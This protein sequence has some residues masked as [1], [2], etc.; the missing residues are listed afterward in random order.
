MSDFILTPPIKTM[1]DAFSVKG[2]NVVIT[3]GNRGIGRGITQAFAESGANIVIL[4]RNEASGKKACE[5]IAQ[6]GGRYACYPCEISSH[7]SV[8]E[9]T[10]KTYEFFDHVDVLVNNA[11]VATTTPL[12]D[13]NGLNEWE[14]VVNTDLNGLAYVIYEFAPKMIDAK[15]GGEII[16][17]SSIGAACSRIR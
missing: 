17:I 5:E 10:K 16:N 14:R 2:K 15:L 3:G 13:P 12:L 7:D 11:G 8:I 4:C 6:F 9:A 1:E